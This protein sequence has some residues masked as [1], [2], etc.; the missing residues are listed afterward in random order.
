MPRSAAARATAAPWLPEECVATPR[1]ASVSGRANTALLAPRALNAPPFWK[2]S[3]LKES[4]VPVSPSSVLL[5]RTG[6]RFTLPAMRSRACSMSSQVRPPDIPGTVPDAV[7]EVALDIGAGAWGG[8]GMWSSRIACGQA[9]LPAVKLRC[10]EECWKVRL[11]GRGACRDGAPALKGSEPLER[12]V[13]I[14]GERVAR[15]NWRRAC[16]ERE[17]GRAG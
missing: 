13:H 8:P 11:L 1:R 16:K 3:H 17:E 9:A 12:R 2:F 7:L 6:V 10:G 15:A 14:D 5:L 4:R